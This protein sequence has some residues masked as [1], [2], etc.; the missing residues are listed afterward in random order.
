MKILFTFL[1]IFILSGVSFAQFDEKKVIEYFESKI[2][3]DSLIDN[4]NGIVS[5]YENNKGNFINKNK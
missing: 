2:K 4:N 3:I 5:Y 1:F